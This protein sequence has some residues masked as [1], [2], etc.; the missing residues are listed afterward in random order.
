MTHS[1]CT[2][3][4]LTHTALPEAKR[5][6]SAVLASRGGA[7]LILTA[8]SNPEAA[9]YFHGLAMRIENIEVIVN[10][11]NHGFIAP[12]NVAFSKCDTDYFVTLN[13]DAIPPPD[14][15]EKLKAA[16]DSP[17]A[18]ISG[19]NA[20]R[21]DDNFVGGKR[22][23]PYDYI[24]ASCMMVAVGALR[25]A[26][27]PLFSEYLNFAYC[28]DADLCLRV[29]KAGFTIHKADFSLFHKSGTTT[30]TVPGLHETMREN[31]AVCREKWADYLETRTFQ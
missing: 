12:N 19:P 26:N 5:C 21:L 29:R 1:D 10:I 15:L 23:E 4:I 31:F 2:I 6:L 27:E 13:D 18:V 28:E 7:K 16:M 8:N 24:E 14:W 30:R 17:M 22:G 11:H 3:S 9:E 25:V 20:F